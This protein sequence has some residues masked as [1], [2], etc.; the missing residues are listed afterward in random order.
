M[1]GRPAAIHDDIGNVSTGKSGPETFMGDG[2]TEFVCT[3]TCYYQDTYY[4]E[5]DRVIPPE[6]GSLPAAYFEK[7]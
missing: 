3:K 4:T 7:N 5:K 2:K 6:G 1:A